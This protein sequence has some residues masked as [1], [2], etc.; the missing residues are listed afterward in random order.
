MRWPKLRCDCGAK[1]EPRFNV[2]PTAAVPLLA[3]AKDGAVELQ[4]ARW[5]LVPAWWNK[6]A[7][8]AMQR[9][10]NGRSSG[11]AAGRYSANSGVER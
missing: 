11:A 2:A 10:R 8:P 1:W 6:D 3:R 4:S 9:Q 5:G 7:P